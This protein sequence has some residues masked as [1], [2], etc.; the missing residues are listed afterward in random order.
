MKKKKPVQLL[1][2]FL[3]FSWLEFG[4]RISHAQELLCQNVLYQLLLKIQNH[5]V[6]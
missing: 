2:F 4:L 1:N 6:P 5:L 3:V